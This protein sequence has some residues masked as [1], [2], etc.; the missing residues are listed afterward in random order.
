L[1]NVHYRK[2]VEVWS[3][4]Y[5]G[6]RPFI[7]EIVDGRYPY[8]VRIFDKILHI[9]GRPEELEERGSRRGART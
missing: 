1:A 6:A 9:A 3:R 8:P 2:F 5:E 4:E 7:D